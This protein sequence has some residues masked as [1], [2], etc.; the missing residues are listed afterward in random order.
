L[1]SN[2]GDV[3][4][5]NVGVTDRQCDEVRLVGGDD[6]TDG[7]LQLDEI[8]RF[9]CQTRVTATTTEEVDA[10]GTAGGVIAHGG[11]EVTVPV[12]A[13]IPGIRV[14][15]VLTPP[16]LP[17][18]GTVALTHSVSNRGNVPLA[19]VVVHDTLCGTLEGPF[20]DINGSATLDIGEVW[21]YVC[22]IAVTRTV[23]E[24][25]D[26]GGEWASRRVTDRDQTTVAVGDAVPDQPRVGIDTLLTPPTL[27]AGGGDLAVRYLV[28]NKGD[29]PLRQLDLSDTLCGRPTYLSGDTNSDTVLGVGEAW[30]FGCTVQITQ[31]LSNTARILADFGGSKIAAAET[32]TV[33]VDP[34]PPVHA[35]PSASAG[36]GASASP[37]STQ[38]SGAPPAT[39]QPSSPSAAP[40]R[41]D[42]AGAPASPAASQGQGPAAT[43]ASSPGPSPAGT[44]P[45]PTVI[46]LV[47]LGGLLASATILTLTAA[48]RRA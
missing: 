17:A 25:V 10:S 32:V 13:A 44:Y 42:V 35:P 8:W 11:N 31:T 29:A 36:P 23:T 39:A 16:S 33:S 45:S 43:Q 4:L 41:I 37:G 1:V 40:S 28:R 48:S 27:P 14:R 21:T 7:V 3:A 24:T 26:A 20:G 46:I 30:L 6:N 9:A 22:S 34:T 38:P 15:S 5:A 2:T 19:N 12:S 18:R 47:A